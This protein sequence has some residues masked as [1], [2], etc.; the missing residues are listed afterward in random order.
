MPAGDD[1]TTEIAN[2]KQRVVAEFW[3]LGITCVVVILAFLSTLYAVFVVL[4]RKRVMKK[5]ELSVYE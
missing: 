4:A 3:M 2:E 5:R 1:E